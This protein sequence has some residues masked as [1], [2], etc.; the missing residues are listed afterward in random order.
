MKTKSVLT[1]LV[2]NKTYFG[3]IHDDYS[4]AGP[5]GK[6]TTVWV[7]K[8]CSSPTDSFSFKNRK[9][10]QEKATTDLSQFVMGLHPNKLIISWKVSQ[11]KNSFNY[12]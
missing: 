8:L 5:E 6:G 4:T 11:V 12:T 2:G 1:L 3:T 9:K 10:Y 7:F